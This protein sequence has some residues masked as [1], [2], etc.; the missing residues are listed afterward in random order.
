MHLLINQED[1]SAKR[2]IFK[3]NDL[4]IEGGNGSNGLKLCLIFIS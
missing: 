1:A 3:T 4:V 2:V